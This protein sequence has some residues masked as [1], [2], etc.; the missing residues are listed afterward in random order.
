LALDPLILKAISIGLALMFLFAAYHKLRDAAGFR[1]T[2]IEYQLLPDV[3][4]APVARA[5]PIAELLLGASWLLGYALHPITAI[6]SAALLGVYALAIGL[7]LA[8]GRVHFDCGC[9]F[10]GRSDNEQYL[11]GGLILRNLVLIAAALA[12]LLPAG[13]R[14]LGAGDNLIL[15]ASLLAGA[16]LFGAANQLLANRAAIDSWRKRP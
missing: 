5:V 13:S 6:A 11:T 10:G 16:L 15:G 4:I 12:T 7:N 2:L 3:L 14:A 9:G 1:V 8:R